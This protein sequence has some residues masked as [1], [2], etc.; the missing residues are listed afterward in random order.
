MQSGF[1][2]YFL[3]SYN[4]FDEEAIDDVVKNLKF[5]IN[6]IS[7][8]LI[9]RALT[10]KAAMIIQ[11]KYDRETIQIFDWTEQYSSA[12]KHKN[13][14]FKRKRKLKIRTISPRNSQI[15]LCYD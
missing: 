5:E 15:K 7:L 6:D 8:L 14:K 12:T 10:D 2:V 11:N 3:S 1:A 4:L 9:S 13:V